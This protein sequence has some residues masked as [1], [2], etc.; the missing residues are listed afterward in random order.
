MQ[1]QVGG[2]CTRLGCDA[3]IPHHTR[4]ALR[5]VVSPGCTFTRNTARLHATSIFQ[6]E[7]GGTPAVWA[8]GSW[9][10][11]VTKMP[12]DGRPKRRRGARGDSRRGAAAGLGAAIVGLGFETCGHLGGTTLESQHEQLHA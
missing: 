4:S 8:G 9:M 6:G 3:S 10:G 12:M 5:V 1:E 7:G 2:I 11:I